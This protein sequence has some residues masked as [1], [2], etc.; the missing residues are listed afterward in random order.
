MVKLLP[1]LTGDA[2]EGSVEYCTSASPAVPSVPVSREISVT[3]KLLPA[4]GEIVNR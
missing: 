3:S 4:L 2:N 1:R